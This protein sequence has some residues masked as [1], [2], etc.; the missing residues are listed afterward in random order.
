MICHVKKFLRENLIIIE[1]YHVFAVKLSSIPTFMLIVIMTNNTVE[2]VFWIEFQADSFTYKANV[3][4]KMER[5][6]YLKSLTKGYRYIVF[7]Y[8]SKFYAQSL[9]SKF[10]FDL[11]A[12]YIDNNFYLNKVACSICMKVEFQNSVYTYPIV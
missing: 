6:A 5:C 10:T 3:R 4:D 12:T 8:V 2:H 9:A 7:T 11:H 1:K